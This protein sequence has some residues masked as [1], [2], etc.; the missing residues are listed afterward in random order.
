[1]VEP[2]SLPPKSAFGFFAPV[3]FW[4]A[5][6]RFRKKVKRELLSR[7]SFKDEIA[8]MW[9]SS[10]FSARETR[11]IRDCIQFNNG[12]PNALFLPS[13]PFLALAPLEI[14][15]YD[16][17]TVDTDTVN[18]IYLILHP[19]EKE[20]MKS[21]RS[22]GGLLVRSGVRCGDIPLMDT[23]LITPEYTIAEVLETIA[24][25]VMS[26]RSRRRCGGGGRGGNCPAG[27]GSAP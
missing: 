18:D 4:G 1:M 2:I 25:A 17:F 11:E 9:A 13:D 10:P 3:P 14:S 6:S 27:T 7:A 22:F 23:S 8:A 12:W 16:A 15:R 20:K 26:G 21:D 5:N 19:E 24:S